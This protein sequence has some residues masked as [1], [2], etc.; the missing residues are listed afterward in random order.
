LLSLPLLVLRQA[1]VAD[2]PIIHVELVRRQHCWVQYLVDKF[3]VKPD[4]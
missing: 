2:T 4:F 3:V 1:R